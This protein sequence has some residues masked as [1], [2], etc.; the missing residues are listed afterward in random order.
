[1]RSRRLLSLAALLMFAVVPIAGAT[2]RAES[3]TPTRSPECRRVQL[4]A[5]AAVQAGAPYRNHGQMV[6]TAARIVG[7]AVDAGRIDEDCASCIVSQFARNVPIA[8]QEPCGDLGLTANLLGPQVGACDG[9][10]AGST[11][12]LDLPNGDS[13]VNVTF[14]NGTPNTTFEVYWTCTSVPN[15]CH[16]SA[17]GFISIGTVTTN[18]SGQANSTFTVVGGNPYPGQYVHLDLCGS[19]CSIVFTSVFP[20]APAGVAAGPGLAAQTGDPSQGTEITA[21]MP[22]G[23]AAKPA[24]G[25]TLPT[26]PKRTWGWVKQ[27]YR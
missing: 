27:I 1:M 14:T 11:S 16:N 15:G 23:L 18:G 9:P 7:R 19:G 12:I 21:A 3:G 22:G 20:T 6:S 17:C 5:Q 26:A 8:E 25:T 2:E 4:E 24:G 10:V 13:Q